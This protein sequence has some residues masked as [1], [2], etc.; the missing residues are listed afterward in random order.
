VTGITY[1]D[2]DDVLVIG[3]DAPGG[4]VEELE[5]FVYRPQA[6]LAAGPEDLQTELVL[7]IQDDEGHQ[8]I[9]HVRPVPALPGE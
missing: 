7:D 8:T 2:K 6:I 5:H 9:V 3:L 1:D 4:H